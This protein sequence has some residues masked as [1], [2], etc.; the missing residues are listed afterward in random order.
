[1]LGSEFE[2]L[3]TDQAIDRKS[4]GTADQYGQ[5]HEQ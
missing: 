3:P 1:M 5:C 2:Y 4:A